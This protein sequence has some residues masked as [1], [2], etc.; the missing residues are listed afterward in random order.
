MLR[1]ALLAFLVSCEGAVGGDVPSPEDASYDRD[2]AVEL[3]AGS[4]R[5][6]LDAA[7][8]AAPDVDPTGGAFLHANLWSTW[9]ND[10]T[11]C[12]AEAVFLRLCE[13]R[14]EGDCS[15]YR[16]AVDACDPWQVVYG[17]IGP[18][19]QGERNCSRGR[20]PEV[21]GCDTTAWD[22][23]T[24]RF[25]WYGAEWAGNWPV[26]TLKVFPAGTR[27]PAALIGDGL[28][29]FSNL[30]GAAQAAMA[31]IAN[32]GVSPHGCAMAG[33]TSGDEAYQTPFGGFAWIEVPTDAPV[34]VA[35]I[36]ATNFGDRPFEGCNRGAAT[37]EPWIEGAPGAFLGCV[38]VQDFQ[39]EPGRHYLWENG[40]IVELP[41]AAPP[42]E[43]VEGFSLGATPRDIRDRENCV[44]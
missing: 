15:D 12:G 23:E 33:A 13:A 5:E 17:Q 28:A 6:G 4:D 7:A 1:P 9:W 34:T 27:D 11:R 20:Y 43:L 18:E 31:G 37:Q 39:F 26:A 14:G 30:P 3:D 19:Q 8:D 2:A 41:E 10:R 25:W 24:L 16:A 22:F 32:H 29:A 44:N 40:I 42:A 21:G 38:Y 35:A 36:A